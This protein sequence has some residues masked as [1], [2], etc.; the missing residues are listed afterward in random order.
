MRENYRNGVYASVVYT[1]LT[2]A[3]FWFPLSVAL[4]TTVTWAFW[5]YFG[6]R[7]KAE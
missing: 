4:V 7:A 2:V 3:A 5:L 6:I 1:L